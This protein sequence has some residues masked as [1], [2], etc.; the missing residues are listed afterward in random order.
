MR[1]DQLKPDLGFEETSLCI[2]ISSIL[3]LRAVTDRIKTSVKYAQIAASIAEVG[4]IE[5][6]V[7]VRS[8]D[9]PDNFALLD[10]HL[11]LAILRERGETEVICLVAKEDEAYTYNKRISRMAIIQE[12]DPQCGS[13]RRFGRTPRQ[14]AECQ[15]LQHPHQAQSAHRD[16]SRSGRSAQEQAYCNPR[17]YRITV[18]KARSAD[19]GCRT[20]DRDEQ[21][22]G[23]LC[24]INRRSN[25]TANARRKS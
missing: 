24:K 25:I 12:H 8:A 16:L 7:V 3:P 14:G 1:K 23:E 18:P 6:P 4:I 9:D 2:P 10:G 19:R 17:F 15:Y 5:A 11:R 21:V 22:F 20:D 13:E